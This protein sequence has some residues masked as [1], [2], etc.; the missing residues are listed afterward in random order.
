M[1]GDVKDGTTGFPSP[2]QDYQESVL[3]LTRLLRLGA[4]GLYPVRVQ[5]S[6]WRRRG[7]LDGDL[8]IANAAA[9]PAPGR[10]CVAFVQG[11]VVLALLE[12]R[13]GT[14]G[15][16]RAGGLLQPVTEAVEIWAIAEA[17]VRL[18]V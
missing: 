9:P 18:K 4:P 14:W 2:A 11:E 5:G 16:K 8:L 13:G 6:G 15:L 17:L 3:D 12:R 1:G 7:I 10:L